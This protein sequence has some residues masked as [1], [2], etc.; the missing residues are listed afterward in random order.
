M[1]HSE[2][3]KLL[4]M[5]TSAEEYIINSINSSH[6][7]TLTNKQIM[8]ILHPVLR[9]EEDDETPVL[10][11]ESILPPDEN[12]SISKHHRFI[13]IPAHQHD[14]IELFYV[15]SGSCTQIINGKKV[16]LS[17]GDMCIL[18]TNVIHSIETT[19]ENDIII[20]CLMRKDYF[21]TSLLSRLSSND[22]ISTFLVHAI[23][24]SKDYNNFIIF[25]SEKREKLHNLMKDLM[26]EYFD[27]SICS[28]EIINCYIILIFSQL[29]QI[30]Q[31][32]TPEVQILNE[33]ANTKNI[34]KIL[35][36][37]QKNY[38]STT[39]AKTAKTF[40]FHP[41]YL[42]TLLKKTTG[43]S[44]KEIIHEQKLKKACTLLKNTDMTVEDI[45]LEVGYNNFSFFYKKFKDAFGVTPLEYRQNKQ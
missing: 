45:S 24:Q 32:Q 18:D 40:N 12:I 13:P 1:N 4:K 23:Y 43:K 26:C 22:L 20:N 21:D 8:T 15:Y 25:H 3:D 19:G 38:I 35:E 16:T 30:Y 34:S 7:G 36:Y 29:L 14:F 2:L 5:R 10:S 33:T 39:L 28:K 31:D 17:Q 6:K 44:F 27:P 41:N 9:W 42:S 37:I 11:G